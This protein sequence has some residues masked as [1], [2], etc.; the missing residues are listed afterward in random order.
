MAKAGPTI[1]M[2]DSE[3]T[4]DEL[5]KSVFE[6][7]DYNFVVTDNI[8]QAVK[9]CRQGNVDLALSNMLLTTDKQ[10]GEKLGFVLLKTLKVLPKTQNIPVIIFTNLVQAEN[11]KQ[12]A[13]LGAID[14]WAKSDYTPKELFKKVSK[15]F[16]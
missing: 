1:L 3:P 15:I 14:F 7:A 12:A 6:Q 16:K 2:F 13:S 10:T 8:N 4:L 9:L 5:Y 11:K